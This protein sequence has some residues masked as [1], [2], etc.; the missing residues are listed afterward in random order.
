MLAVTVG[1][2]AG[3]PA[4]RRR[5]ESVSQAWVLAAVQFNDGGAVVGE[6]VGLRRRRERPA[7]VTDGEESGARRH[8][9]VVGNVE[10]LD[11]ARGRGTRRRGRAGAHAALGEGGPQF[12][13]VRAAVVHQVG[14][15]DGVARLRGRSDSPGESFMPSVTSCRIIWLPAAAPSLL[16]RLARASHSV[17]HQTS[18]WL[19]TSDGVHVGRAEDRAV[20]HRGV[21]AGLRRDRCP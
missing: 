7:P 20:R 19:W 21:R 18:P 9:Q 11:H 17:T 15:D 10:G 3:S 8:P 4:C 12:V 13:L 2:R 5:R 14:L 16:I 6:R 1:G